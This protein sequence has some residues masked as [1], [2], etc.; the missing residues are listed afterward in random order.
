MSYYGDL[1]NDHSYEYE[2]SVRAKEDREETILDIK[3]ALM[4]LSDEA[5]MSFVLKRGE[6]MNRPGLTFRVYDV[7]KKLRDRGWSPTVGQRRAIINV[8]AIAAYD[9]GYVLEEA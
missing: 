1:D 3:G 2:Q 5:L 7:C 8:A 9:T 4:K 6:R